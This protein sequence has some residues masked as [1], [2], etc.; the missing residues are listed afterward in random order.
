MPDER[1]T[2]L[3]EMIIKTAADMRPLEVLQVVIKVDSTQG[4]VAL[5]NDK[6]L[7]KYH[8]I[9]EAGH[10]KNL[11]KNPV[12][13]KAIQEVEKEIRPQDLSGGPI[14][15][16]AVAVV[17]AVVKSRIRRNG[18]SSREL[19]TRRDQYSGKVY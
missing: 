19:W 7:R 18:L 17:T 9:L 8:I 11:N 14:T 13:K 15:A 4:F 2:I 3:R 10:A 16:A 6:G 5:V 1:H 12:L